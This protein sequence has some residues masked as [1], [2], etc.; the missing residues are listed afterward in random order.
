[1]TR[2]R[3]RAVRRFRDTG[4]FAAVY[5]DSG[6]LMERYDVVDP[7]RRATGGEYVV[8]DGFGWTNGVLL[9]LMDEL[10]IQQGG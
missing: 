9:R 7:G 1:M 5:A 10:G 3:S 2:T 6:R 8:Q 4:K